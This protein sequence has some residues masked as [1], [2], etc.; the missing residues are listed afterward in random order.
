MQNNAGLA[1]VVKGC[2]SL[3]DTSHIGVTVEVLAVK[4]PADMHTILGGGL[5]DTS[6]FSGAT[7]GAAWATKRGG[8]VLEGLSKGQP[9]LL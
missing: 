8:G 2:V 4:S 3:G 5:G 9:V 1:A 6:H 7:G